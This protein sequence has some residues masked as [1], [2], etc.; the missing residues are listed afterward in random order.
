MSMDEIAHHEAGHV[1]AAFVNGVFYFR[2]IEISEDGTGRV[3]AGFLPFSGNAEE[4][5]LKRAR[6]DVII[7]LA[8]GFAQR[9]YLESRGASPEDAYNRS[10]KTSTAD[11]LGAAGALI[12][13]A[14]DDSSR[15]RMVEEACN[16][17]DKHWPFVERVA[18]K[19]LEKNHLT[20][21]EIMPLLVPLLPVWRA[22]RDSA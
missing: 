8:S 3:D 6:T 7:S 1:V 18:L 21:H 11:L 20:H 22:A 14:P 15:Y 19:L 9:R 10:L 2:T 17:V 13:I 16:L 12:A 5:E 4:S